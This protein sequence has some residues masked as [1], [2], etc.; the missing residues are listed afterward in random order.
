M[1]EANIKRLVEKL[2]RMRGAALKL[3][4]FMSIQGGVLI[5]YCWMY[6]GDLFYFICIVGVDTH[7]L[8]PEIDSILRRV[9]DSAHYMPDWQMEVSSFNF[10]IFFLSFASCISLCLLNSIYHP[11]TSK[12]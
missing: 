11:P 6:D 2:S 4:Q 8:P 12:S 5:Y 7:M 3:G 1:T 9:Q 10:S